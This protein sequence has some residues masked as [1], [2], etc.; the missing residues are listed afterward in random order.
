MAAV[1][2]V[3]TLGKELLMLCTGRLSYACLSESVLKVLAGE[4]HHEGAAGP[5]LT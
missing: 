1:I 5:E 3:C 4:A 2:E